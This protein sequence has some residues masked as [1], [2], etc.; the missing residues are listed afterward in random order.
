MY[1]FDRAWA[2]STGRPTP[3]N[4]NRTDGAYVRWPLGDAA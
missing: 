4:T 1:P 2:E 3:N